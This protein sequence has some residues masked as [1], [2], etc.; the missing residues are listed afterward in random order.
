MNVLYTVL[1]TVD[2]QDSEGWHQWTEEEIVSYHA[3][4]KSAQK[5]IK[6]LIQQELY[7]IKSC[8]YSSVEHQLDRLREVEQNIHH[9]EYD[10]EY[11]GTIKLFNVGSINIED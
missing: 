2:K 11:Y 7:R 8:S 3:T 5:K 9:V 10:N 1:K 4:L 6:K